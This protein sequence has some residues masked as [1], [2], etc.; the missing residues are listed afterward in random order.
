[1][2][3]CWFVL[4][5]RHYP[6][7]V[8]AHPGMA[9]GFAVGPIRL[10]HFVAGPKQLD[11]VLNPGDD[12]VAPF[13]KDMR[14]WATE[15]AQ[16]RL[17]REEGHV[18]DNGAG[19]NVPFAAAVGVS[20]G[21]EAGAVFRKMMGEDWE[22]DALETQIVQPTA[23]YLEK[24][25]GRDGRVAEWVERHKLLGAWK[26]YMISGIIVA[27]GAK[28]ARTNTNEVGVNVGGG[29]DLIGAAGAKINIENR[30]E[31]EVKISGQSMND[32]V[33]A[34]RLTEVSK[35]L[36]RSEIS[37]RTTIKGAVFASGPK[38]FDVAKVLA[39]T[40]L[41]GVNV[42]DVEVLHGED[43]EHLIALDE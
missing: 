42:H 35:S 18:Y 6:A 26:V 20:V 23:A 36:F 10:G 2:E 39:E 38:K 34:V 14:I 9:H 24:C 27:R 7:P 43:L 8:Y 3:K 21:A 5:Q 12:D 40:G 17:S 22:I 16:F 41:V 29:V 25:C 28:F 4:R 32:F 33:W 31:N 30:K 13:P 11:Q 15:T 1:M 19:A 37:Q